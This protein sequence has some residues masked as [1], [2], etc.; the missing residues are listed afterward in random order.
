MPLIRWSSRQN[1]DLDGPWGDGIV[2]NWTEHRSTLYQ[3][4]VKPPGQEGQ[5]CYWRD[6]GPVCLST[7]DSLSVSDGDGGSDH[8]RFLYY[9]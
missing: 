3:I 5:S 9:S 1:V 8:I 4:I 6:Q 7:D 2:L